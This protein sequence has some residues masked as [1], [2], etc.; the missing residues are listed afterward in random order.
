MERAVNGER[1][2]P[3]SGPTGGPDGS[4]PAGRRARRALETRRR[5]LDAA[6]DLFVS[7]G[8]GA[9]T[10][11]GVA[12]VAGVAVQTVY[13]VFGNKRVML[14]EVLDRAIAG[15]D[16]PVAVNDREWMAQV[17]EAPTAPARLVA[18]AAA[19]R[20]ILD[21]AGDVFA[22]VTAAASVDPDVVELA[23][24]S[25]ARRREGAEAVVAS[26]LEVGALRPGLDRTGAVDLLSLLNGPAV[27]QHLVR[28]SGWTPD[29]YEAWLAGAMVEQLLGRA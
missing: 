13:A 29:R 26:V 20:Q 17:W 22:A 3:R 10:I 7:D 6:R 4:P 16:R 1:P 15:D 19:V 27:H 18:Y 5:I 11:Q 2:A 25:E 14:A 9:T 8:Y 28:R 21:R 12:D 24:T 23:A